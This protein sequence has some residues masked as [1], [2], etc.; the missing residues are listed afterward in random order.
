[1]NY[2][3]QWYQDIFLNY[4]W[5]DSTHWV[6]LQWKCHKYFPLTHTRSIPDPKFLKRFQSGSKSRKV[7]D[8]LDP[9]PVQCFSSTWL[10]NFSSKATISFWTTQRITC[11]DV[12]YLKSKKSDF[13]TTS[14]HKSKTYLSTSLKWKRP[15]KPLHIYYCGP[16]A[17][18]L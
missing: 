2:D 5:S 6:F 16:R 11:L 8:S 18:S 17:L 15:P 14:Q 13:Y 4:F 1:M 7:S 10:H 3:C 9:N 12:K